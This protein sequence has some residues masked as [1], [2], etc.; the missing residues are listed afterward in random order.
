MGTRTLGVVVTMLFAL[1]LPTARAWAQDDLLGAALPEGN[2]VAVGVGLYPDYIGSDDY[3]VGA[4]P[5]ARY[6][7]W[8]KRDV[9]LIGN[10]LTV[11][12]LDAGGWR[13]GPSG[14][15]RFGR[16]DV[17]D[18][19]VD[20]VH[21]IDPSIDLGAFAGYT[22]VHPDEPRIRVGASVWVLAD[23]TDSHGGWTA[24]GNVF[25]SYPVFKALTLLS[26]AGFTYGSGSYM[27]A[28]FGVTP[29]DAQASGLRTYQADAGIRDV[30]GWLVALLHLSPNWT[31]GAGIVY[32]RLA[33]E[34]GDS[35]IV[36][37]RGSRDQ[38]VAGAGAMYIW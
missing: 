34:A 2:L 23:V 14:I 18:D 10:T 29:A 31:I 12:L 32:S 35:P 9:Q 16:S 11:N 20:R 3:A 24:G 26:G 1:A 27:S 21:E 15:L 33:D 17:E 19:V 36:S 5:L 8:G 37:D 6:Q 4:I 13:L 28:Y 22:W 38:W 30:R 25:G 7:Y